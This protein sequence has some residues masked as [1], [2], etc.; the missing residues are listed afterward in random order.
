[1]V[2]LQLIPRMA[3]RAMEAYEKYCAIKEERSR[4]EARS[5]ELKAAMEK[6]EAIFGTQFTEGMTDRR[7]PGGK[8]VHCKTVNVAEHI[9]KAYSYHLYSEVEI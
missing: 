1:M 5:R 6:Q 8:L 2:D 4:V 9:Q 7:I 3:P